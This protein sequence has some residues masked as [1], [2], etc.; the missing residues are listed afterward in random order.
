MSDVVSVLRRGVGKEQE[1][2]DE[3]GSG[4]CAGGIVNQV[5]PHW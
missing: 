3:G 2:R 1:V 5:H 4:S